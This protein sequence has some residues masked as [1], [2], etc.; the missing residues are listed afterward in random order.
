MLTTIS[1]EQLTERL[2]ALAA[3]QGSVDPASVTA[4]T[5]LFNDLNYDSLDAVEFVMTIED[6]FNVHIPDEQAETVKTVGQAV[7]LLWPLVSGRGGNTP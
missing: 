2:C 6:E 5:H 7:E 4:E 3:E 1:R